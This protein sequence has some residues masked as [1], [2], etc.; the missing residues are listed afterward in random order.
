MREGRAQLE[1]SLRGRD[2][3]EHL[4]GAIDEIEDAARVL[5]NGG[6]HPDAVAHLEEASRLAEKAL[7]ASRH[8]NK[9]EAARRKNTERALRELEAARGT[10]VG[11]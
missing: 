5:E 10:M 4:E 3:K 6:L 8:G 11:S 1:A 2:R 7:R 9:E